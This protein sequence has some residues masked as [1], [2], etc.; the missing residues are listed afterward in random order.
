MWGQVMKKKPEVKNL[1]LLS[2]YDTNHRQLKV[3]SKFERFF[4]SRSYILKKVQKF[5]FSC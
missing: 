2:F 4:I 1:V 5:K 3:L